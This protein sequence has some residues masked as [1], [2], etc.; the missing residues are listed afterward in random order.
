MGRRTNLIL[1]HLLKSITT[2]EIKLPSVQIIPCAMLGCHLGLGFSRGQ[3]R[4]SCPLLS[5]AQL[6]AVS[7]V[8]VFPVCSVACGQPRDVAGEE[9][10]ET[11]DLSSYLGVFF[12]FVLKGMWNLSS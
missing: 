6:P 11:S 12:C 9:V 2:F 7:R 10:W 1:P 4:D 8:A 5:P 3:W